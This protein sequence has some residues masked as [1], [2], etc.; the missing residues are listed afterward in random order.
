MAM[1]GKGYQKTLW[2]YQ[3]RPVASGKLNAWDDISRKLS[4]LFMR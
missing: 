4:N 3:E 1:K 2:S